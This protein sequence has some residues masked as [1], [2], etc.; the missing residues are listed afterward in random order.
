NDFLE[1]SSFKKEIALK[2]ANKNFNEL[3]LIAAELR[4]K[5]TRMLSGEWKLDEF[6]FGLISDY[7]KF[8]IS[9]MQKLISRLSEWKEVNPSSITATTA[10]VYSTKDLAWAYRK[11]GYADNVTKEGKDGFFKHLNLAFK[12]AKEG[13]SLSE[14]DP[15]L[16]ANW[17]SVLL[18]MNA[19]IDDIMQLVEKSMSIAPDY[20]RTFEVTTTPLLPRWGAPKGALEDFSEWIT[21][22]T[23]D[24]MG[25]TLYTR[26]AVKVKNYVGD[27]YFVNFDFDWKKIKKGFKEL[28]ELF[29][30]SFRDLNNFTW[31]ACYYNDKATAQ[32]L[33]PKIDTLWDGYSKEI[34]KSK[35]VFE[36]WKNWAVSKETSNPIQNNPLHEAV[37]KGNYLIVSRLISNAND[38]I[39][40]Q[41]INGQTPLHLALQYNQ[42][43]IAK[44][45]LNADARLDI[46]NNE[47]EQAIHYAARYGLTAMI[48][49]FLE[50]GI[51]INVPA[52]GT[53]Y[54]PLHL[55]A[56]NNQV[57][58]V[59]YLLNNSN[60]NINCVDKWHNTPLHFAAKE[61][62]T[63][64]VKT[65]LSRK[66]IF[67]NPLTNDWITPLHLA[68]QNGYPDTAS[69]F[70]EYNPEINIIDKYGNTPLSLAIDGNYNEIIKLLEESDAKKDLI[71]TTE[72]DIDLGKKLN[73]EGRILMKNKKYN[74]ALNKY[75]EASKVYPQ[76]DAMYYNAALILFHD[77]RQYQEAYELL[78]KTLNRNPIYP[79]A[80]YL[81]GRTLQQLNQTEEALY[82]FRRYIELAPNTDGAKE[83]KIEFSEL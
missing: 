22:E 1:T 74:E 41:N 57:N 67:I 58:T 9:S 69:I 56:S 16:Y 39:N 83:L 30:N 48:K 6:Y 37:Q 28:Q 60:I 45:L 63:Q 70:F 34:W 19:P 32:E 11:R 15:R 40:K 77:R 38:E 80:N 66:E 49:E 61:G 23:H 82:F 10:L 24:Y 27:E 29:P 5:K 78:I 51:N 59:L 31:F 36:K 35:A 47:G 68:L 17:V 12:I 44:L 20:H 14:K 13:E 3:D 76:E 62:N 53:E 75:F 72:D 4:N 42:P 25:N 52:L 43:Y 71:K 7:D 54:T 26:L 65:L 46:T 33:F 21:K 50:N 18:G 55:A 64:I 8:S 2:L 73:D 79:E 81:I